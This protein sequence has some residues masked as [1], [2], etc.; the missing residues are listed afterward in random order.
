MSAETVATVDFHADGEGTRVELDQ[1]GFADERERDMHA[2]G[3]GGCL[4]NLA[5]RVLPRG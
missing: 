5:R 1:A 3:W 4:D 2:D